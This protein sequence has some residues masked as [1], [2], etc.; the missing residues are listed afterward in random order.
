VDCTKDVYFYGNVFVVHK[1]RT[2]GLPSWP[3]AAIA[4]GGV[5]VLNEEVVGGLGIPMQMID[6]V[7]EKE[8]QEL[9]RR[10][11]AYRGNFL[12]AGRRRQNGDSH[13]RW[14]CH[15]FDY[16]R[17]KGP[18]TGPADRRCADRDRLHLQQIAT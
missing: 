16:A 17:L 6:A 11:L 1:L 8:T 18:R 5:R 2:P 4:T 12:G 9:K 7:T 10:Q 14:N 13:R 3:W 15:W